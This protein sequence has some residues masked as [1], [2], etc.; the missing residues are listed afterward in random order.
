MM[1]WF[2]LAL[3]P[4]VPHSDWHPICEYP[5]LSSRLTSLSDLSAHKLHCP[6]DALTVCNIH[7]DGFQCGGGCCCQFCCTFLCE[8]CS[9]DAETFLIQLS[10]Q[11]IPKATVTSCDKDVLLSEA[12]NYV[13]VSDVPE[14]GS[15]GSQK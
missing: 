8:T 3:S 12:F 13:G 1:R 5:L 11:Q 10:G 4:P 9:Y 2:R 14:E 6:L 15:N 7:Q